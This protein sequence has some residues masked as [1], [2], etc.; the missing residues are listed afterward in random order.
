MRSCTHP[1]QVDEPGHLGRALGSR[2]RPWLR[3]RL[4]LIA[5]SRAR[6]ASSQVEI[7]IGSPANGLRP[8][9]VIA[10]QAAS[11][12]EGMRRTVG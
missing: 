5:P 12:T 3:S 1:V 9:L 7:L 10:V 2:P 8:V 6:N 4:V 11:D